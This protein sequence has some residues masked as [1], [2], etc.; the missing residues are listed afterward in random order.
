MKILSPAELRLL[1]K[2]AKLYYDV[3]L[4]Q[5]EIVQRLHLSRSKV[6]RLLSQAREAGIV[7]I[8]VISPPGIYS[9]L[10][11][12]IENRFRI[13]EVIVTEVRQPDD[14]ESVAIE[15]GRAAAAYMERTIKDN[16]VVGFSW[17]STLNA[18]ADAMT[19]FTA[20][21]TQVV[22]IIGSWDSG[23]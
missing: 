8:T 16:H 15:L 11:T 20:K 22:Q 17:G 3:G 13:E 10:E 4:N 12:Q 19:P 21:D 5:D 7:K 1:T 14:Q 2:V 23:R 6:S 18:M 9:D